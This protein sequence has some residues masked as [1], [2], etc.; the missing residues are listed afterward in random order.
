MAGQIGGGLTVCARSFDRQVAVRVYINLKGEKLKDYMFLT[1]S[2]YHQML[3]QLMQLLKKDDRIKNIRTV[4]GVS[5]GGLPIAVHLSHFMEWKF[6]NDLFDD[7]IEHT[8]IVDDIAH[9]G[10]TLARGSG[11]Y[12]TATLFYREESVIKPDFYV[13]KATKWIVF[14]WEKPDETPNRPL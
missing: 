2:V 8:L 5:R 9:T 12:L 4:Y 7:W 13:A 11:L 3:D 6:A 14:P 10:K 1:Y